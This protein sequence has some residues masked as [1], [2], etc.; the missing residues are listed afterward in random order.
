MRRLLARLAL[1][2]PLAAACA[3]EP[4]PRPTAVAIAEVKFADSLRVDLAAM[5]RTPSG[6]YYRDVVEGTGAVVA[7]GQEVAMRYTGWLPD[8]TKFD[9]NVGG[10]PFVFRLG[11]GM[12]IQGWDEGVEGMKVGGRRQLVIPPSLGYGEQ[13]VG[14]IPGNA[15]LV[16]DV[17]A[18]EV[19]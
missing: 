14:P 7:K 11:A 12:V 16:F 6:L 17:E 2:V 9:S 19:R 13:G 18:L 8:G 4:A 3:Q 15:V 5:T 10:D 1:L